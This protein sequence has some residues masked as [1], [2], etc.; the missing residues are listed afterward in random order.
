MPE[1]KVYFLYDELQRR[2]AALYISGSL[3]EVSDEIEQVKRD[4]RLVRTAH[5]AL[6]E[7]LAYLGRMRA[8]AVEARDNP[9]CDRAVLSAE[10]ETLKGKIDRAAAGN[11][12]LWSSEEAAH[13]REM[14]A[15]VDRLNL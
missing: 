15:A 5:N 11:L 3:R 10:L 4:M 7:I 1:G 8:I 9:K 13:L 12:A 14:I 2:E 6:D